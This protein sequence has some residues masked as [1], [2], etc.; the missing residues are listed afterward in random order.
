MSAAMV[1]EDAVTGVAEARAETESTLSAFLRAVD[2]TLWTV[3]TFSGFGTEH[4]AGLVGRP[5]AVV[6]ATLALDIHDDLDDLSF[7]DEAQRSAR[8]GAY[9]ALDDAGLSRA[10]RRAHAG[11]R[12][13]ARVLRRR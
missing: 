5:I 4:I 8:E 13:A 9:E 6:R 2:T 3:D 7:A 11:R 12:R 10:P 1:A